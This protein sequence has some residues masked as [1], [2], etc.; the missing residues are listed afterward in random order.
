M[1][2]RGRVLGQGRAKFAIDVEHVEGAA[3][4]RL[5]FRARRQV[6]A[7][8]LGVRLIG[9]ALTAEFGP[10]SDAKAIGR[11]GA[12]QAIAAELPVDLGAEDGLA[13]RAVGPR[14]DIDVVERRLGDPADPEDV[15]GRTPGMT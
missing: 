10:E 13:G 1:Q 12:F 4:G 3:D 6:A 7:G 2:P 11:P 15:V 9:K 8:E 5:G 14:G